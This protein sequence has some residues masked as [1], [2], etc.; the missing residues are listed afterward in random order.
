MHYFNNQSLANN[1]GLQVLSKTFKSALSDE[2][3][4][5]LTPLEHVQQTAKRVA[6]ST[7]EA[8]E[9][10]QSK[11]TLPKPPGHLANHDDLEDETLTPLQRAQL[12][13]ERVA[14]STGEAVERLQGSKLDQSPHQAVT[15]E[16]PKLP[17]SKN[18][19][20]RSH[21]HTTP[22]RHVAP[23]TRKLENMRD[24]EHK[25]SLSPL[26]R[27]EIAA[28]RVALSTGKSLE[29]LSKSQTESGLQHSPPLFEST[30]SGSDTSTSG[31][32]CSRS[33]K[34]ETRLA[35]ADRLAGL[36]HLSSLER[37]RRTAEMVAD[38]TGAAVQKLSSSLSDSI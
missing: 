5:S 4:Q 15:G 2:E 19:A 11:R 1:D 22:K 23:D 28:K 21:H 9:R 12:T 32:E 17:G 8:V 36:D 14:R 16:Q 34:S 31:S 18:N 38:S 6:Q 30:E 24:V 20:M 29:K 26:E 37:V 35:S 27:A 3:P 33:T 10:L 25:S 7:G 13:A